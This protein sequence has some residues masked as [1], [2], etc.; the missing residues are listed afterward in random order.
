MDAVGTAIS[1]TLQYGVPL[2][3]M[4]DKFS[5]SRFDPSGITANREIPFAKS[6]VDYIFRWLAMEFIEG[7]RQSNSPQRR[8]KAKPAGAVVDSGGN[9]GSSSKGGNGDGAGG[10][11]KGTKTDSSLERVQASAAPAGG[12]QASSPSARLALPLAVEQTD[13]SVVVK[14][15]PGLADRYDHLAAI[16]AEHRRF[17]TDAPICYNCGAIAVPNGNCSPCFNCG[18]SMRC[19]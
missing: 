10:G 14:V 7:Y 5:H 17:Q 12:A 18:C 4:V 13:T 19:A 8:A 3:T 1:L 9:G 6:I 11:S 16:Q 15:S 2:Q